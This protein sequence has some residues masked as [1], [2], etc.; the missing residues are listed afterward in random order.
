MEKNEI[1][2]KQVLPD[3]IEAKS[4]AEANAINKDLYRFEKYSE[5]RDVYIYIKRRGK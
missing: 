1:Y 2:S 3:V 4:A 5:T